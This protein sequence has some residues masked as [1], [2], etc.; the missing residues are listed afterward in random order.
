MSA[1][2][3][4]QL[5]LGVGLDDDARISNFLVSQANRQLVDTLFAAVRS[6][7]REKARWFG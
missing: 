1:L 7:P 3:P 4:T 2:T 5:V 6:C